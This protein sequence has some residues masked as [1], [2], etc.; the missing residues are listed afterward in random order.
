MKILKSV[1]IAF[2]LAIAAG[3]FSTATAADARS[4]SIVKVVEEHISA[5]ETAINN[6]SDGTEVAAHIKK[7]SDTTEEINA[8]DKVSRENAKVRQHLRAAST[9]AKAANL[10]DAKEHLAKAK[11]SLANLKKMI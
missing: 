5:A 9:S 2:S 6:G 3:S 1:L 7:A 4:L 11:E 8:N 10:Q